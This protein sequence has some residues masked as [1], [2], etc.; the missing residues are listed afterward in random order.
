MAEP[1]IPIASE[2]IWNQLGLKDFKD[3]DYKDLV[4]G[5]IADGTVVHKATRSSRELK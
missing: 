4:W 3:A 2:K 5:G 1:V